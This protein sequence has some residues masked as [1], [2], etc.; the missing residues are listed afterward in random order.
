MQYNWIIM[1]KKKLLCR[2]KDANYSSVA[3]TEGFP[4][5]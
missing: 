4:G 2:K 3:G 1:G 5:I